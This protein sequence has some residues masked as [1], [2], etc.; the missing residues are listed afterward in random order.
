MLREHHFTL[1]VSNCY[2]IARYVGNYVAH[3]DASILFALKKWERSLLLTVAHYV[4]KFKN[5]QLI[6]SFPNVCNITIRKN[7]MVHL[8]VRVLSR[9][10]NKSENY[11][12]NAAPQ[13]YPSQISYIANIFKPD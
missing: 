6:C 3:A 7:Q 5:A 9:T 11:G 4:S 10:R 13:K 8:K 12:C 2:L 1:Y